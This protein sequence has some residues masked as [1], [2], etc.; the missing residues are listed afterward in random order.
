MKI[1]Y[2]CHPISGDVTGNI[3]KLKRIIR[4]ESLKDNQVLPFAPYLV[5]LLT[6]HDD[7][8][9]ERALGISHNTEIFTRKLIDEVWLYGEKI[10]S[11]MWHEI[12]LA[13]SFGIPVM[14]KTEA[15]SQAYD[16]VYIEFMEY[17]D[18]IGDEREKL[19]TLSFL[20]NRSSVS[21]SATG[22]VLTFTPDNH[23]HH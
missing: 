3:A 16:P 20:R 4:D 7:R 9:E 15:T 6:L 22:P 2:I 21:N 13:W 18:W 10:S 23:A 5:D 1:C 14:A 11:G 17:A 8:P 19:K 12:K